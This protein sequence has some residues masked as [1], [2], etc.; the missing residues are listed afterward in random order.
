MRQPDRYGFEESVS[1]TLV[2]MTGDFYTYEK[3]VESHDRDRWIQM[4]SEKIQSLHENQIAV[5]A[6]ATGEETLGCKWIYQHKEGP[7]E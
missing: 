2:T 3:V 1:Y 7:L 5:S 4:M 6:A